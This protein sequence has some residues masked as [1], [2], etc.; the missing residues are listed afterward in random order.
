MASYETSAIA[1]SD[2]EDDIVADSIGIIITSSTPLESTTLTESLKVASHPLLDRSLWHAPIIYARCHVTSTPRE[3]DPD[4]LHNLEMTAQDLVSRGAVVIVTD[5]GFSSMQR[6]LATRMSVPVL[7]SAMIQLSGL[8]LVTAHGVGVVTLDRQLLS[9]WNLVAVG[10]SS[11]TP[12]IGLA[13][14]S[15]WRQQHPGPE[16]AS[17]LL[18]DLVE[19]CEELIRRHC[20]SVIVLEDPKFAV[21]TGRIHA[22]LPHIRFFDIVT[23]VSWLYAGHKQ[24]VSTTSAASLS[25]SA[26]Q[27]PGTSLGGRKIR[28]HED[29]DGSSLGDAET[30][31]VASRESTPQFRD[32]VKLRF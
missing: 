26:M 31:P 29:Q 8:N 20:V 22:R 32:E 2:E 16:S 6:D 25:S 21:F 10:A 9:S 18:Y 17:R 13:S 27:I 19:A 3:Y 23:G 28:H 15:L 30:M 5:V 14:S 24:V 11:D 7:C 12:V 4:S 1:S